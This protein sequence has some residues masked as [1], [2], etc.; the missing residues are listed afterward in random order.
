[1]L[2][3][4]RRL[5]RTVVFTL[6]GIAALCGPALSSVALAQTGDATISAPYTREMALPGKMGGFTIINPGRIARPVCARKLAEL[7]QSR[8]GARRLP[9]EVYDLYGEVRI[10]WNPNRLIYESV[11]YTFSTEAGVVVTMSCTLSSNKAVTFS[12]EGYA[13]GNATL[14]DVRPV[15]D[16]HFRYFGNQLEFHD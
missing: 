16:G 4:F 1:M 5:N 8:E 13:R 14:A 15:I 11:H 10:P 7:M 9:D 6:A 3:L 12:V 2:Q